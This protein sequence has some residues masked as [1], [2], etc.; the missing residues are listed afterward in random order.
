MWHTAVF[1]RINL[2]LSSVWA[3]VFLVCALL[4][5]DAEQNVAKGLRD[6][7]NW[8]I[9]IA[10]IFLAFRFTKSYPRQVRAQQQ[11]QRAEHGGPGPRGRPPTADLGVRSR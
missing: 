4:G 10:A 2:V 1:K 9:P 7:L 6:W 5:L 8:Y 11:A 3:A